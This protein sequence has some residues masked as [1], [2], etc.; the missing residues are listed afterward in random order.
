[1]VNHPNRSKREGFDISHLVPKAATVVHSDGTVTQY[2]AAAAQSPIPRDI[3]KL[4]AMDIGKAVAAHIETMYP[5]AVTATGSTFLLSVRNCTHNEIMAAL[6]T[7]DVDAI[8]ARL[9]RRKEQRRWIKAVVKAA[10]MIPD[11]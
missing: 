5:D 10:R 8:L 3:V 9:E 11:I 2:P 6:D 7:S 1:M 4:I